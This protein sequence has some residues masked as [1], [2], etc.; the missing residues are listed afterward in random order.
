MQKIIIVSEAI[1][2]IEKHLS[3]KLNLEMVCNA[4]HYS[5]YYLHRVFSETVGLSIHAYIQRR[6]LT[7]AAKLLVFSDKP[8]IEIALIAGYESQQAF[9]ATFKAMYKKSPN[10]YREAEAFY[11]LQLPY[12]LN[13]EPTKIETQINWETDIT[14]ATNNDI[15]KW[16][17]FVYLVID[18]FPCLDEKEYIEALEKSILKQQAMLLKDKDMVIGAM[19]LNVNAGCIDFLGIH[20]QYRKNG[21]AKAFLQKAF[22][23]LLKDMAISITTFREGDKAD[24]GYRN[25]FKKLGFAEAELLVEYGYPTQ[26]FTL[27]KEDLEV[28]DCERHTI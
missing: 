25:A 26:K 23:E 15:P 27:K 5:K 6:Q 11:P 4:V 16:M 28:N 8:I 1:N 2:Y 12:V 14:F 7:E 22:S 9:T 24:L 10:Q 18:G 17:D 3:D 20:P 19:A 21:I 13:K